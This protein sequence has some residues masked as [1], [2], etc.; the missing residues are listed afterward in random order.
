ML[1]DNRATSNYVF[2]RWTAIQTKLSAITKSDNYF[3]KDI[4]A[5]KI[6]KQGKPW[7]EQLD[8]QLTSLQRPTSYN[9]KR[10]MLQ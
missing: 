5:F 10:L 8:R 2:E 9:P 3:A 7:K 1:E 4:K 6:L